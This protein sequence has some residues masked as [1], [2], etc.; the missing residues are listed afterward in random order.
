[1]HCAPQG[2]KL[3]CIRN[4]DSVCLTIV[5]AT[6]VVSRKFTTSYS[7]VVIRAK[8]SIGLSHEEKMEALRLFISK[9]SPN[10]VETGLKYAEKSFHRT[11]IIRLDII[12][13]S[14]KAKVVT[15]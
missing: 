12:S 9:Y 6:N 5:G 4:N 10:D 7:S 1:L 13:V 3:D 14:G 15:P 8:A 11:E 2:E